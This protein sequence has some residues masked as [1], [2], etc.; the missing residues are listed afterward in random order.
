MTLSLT[1]ISKY[2]PLYGTI[3]NAMTPPEGS[4]DEIKQKL[5]ERGSASVPVARSR[6]APGGEK[7]NPTWTSPVPREGLTINPHRLSFLKKLLI[8]SG[9]FFLVILGFIIYAFYHDSVFVS[10]A[11]VVLSIE[12][13]DK[14]RAGDVVPLTVTIKNDNS[15]GLESVNLFLQYPDGTRQ[16]EDKETLLSRATLP[17][18]RIAP[19]Q[20]VRQT[21]KVVLLGEVGKSVAVQAAVEYRL[22]DSNAIFDKTV[23]Q[24]F[25]LESSPVLLTL[26]APTEA[27]SG[28]EVVYTINLASNADQVLHQLM[29]TADYPNGFHF[30]SSTPAPVSDGPNNVWL[31]GDLAAGAKREVKVRGTITG[32]A[33]AEQGFRAGV[34][35]PSASDPRR[36]GLTLGSVFDSLIIRRPYL[37]LDIALN[38]E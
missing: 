13:V 18:G 12:T 23:T 10:P 34:G 16:A 32:E 33:D 35:T 21:V 26:E 27:S 7:L 9:L 19:G 4:L 5:Y 24:E 17:I 28:D 25:F 29:V 6:L 31:I 1:A 30:V 37:T 20:E 14:I 15:V 22:T 11:N 2:F 36:L 8:I 3:M 38:G